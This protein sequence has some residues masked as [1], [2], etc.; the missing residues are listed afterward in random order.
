MYHIKVHDNVFGYLQSAESNR[1]VVMSIS[2]DTDLVKLPSDSF[3]VN[4]VAPGKIQMAMDHRL[5]KD[6]M[7]SLLKILDNVGDRE[8]SPTSDIVKDAVKYFT[9]CFRAYLESQLVSRGVSVSNIKIIIEIKS[10]HEDS[11]SAELTHQRFVNY[12]DSGKIVPISPIQY[13]YYLDPSILKDWSRI[14]LISSLACS[15]SNGELKQIQPRMS[16]GHK[17]NFTNYMIHDDLRSL[18]RYESNSGFEFERDTNVILTRKD[19]VREMF[20][21]TMI[22]KD[23]PYF[24]PLIT[25]SQW[26]GTK[27]SSAPV[28]P[29]TINS[30]LSIFT[31][32]DIRSVVKDASDSLLLLDK[33]HMT[34]RSTLR[35]TAGIVKTMPEIFLRFISEEK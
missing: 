31:C 29:S 23:M 16:A 1:R 5:I 12:V 34:S 24:F 7:T 32:R 35:S 14:I 17:V 27:S 19:I 6:G 28:S 26:I 13:K 22:G 20:I 33:T 15:S 8:V 18:A 9:T 21:R 2:N 30:V 11:S 25:R 3:Q 4:M 10:L